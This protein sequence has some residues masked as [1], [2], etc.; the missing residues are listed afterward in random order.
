[1]LKNMDAWI[2]RALTILIGG[3]VF[4]LTLLSAFSTSAGEERNFAAAGERDIAYYNFYLSDSVLLHIAVLFIFIFAVTAVVRKFNSR[5]NRVLPKMEWVNCFIFFIVGMLWI[6]LTRM[7]PISVFF[8]Y[9]HVTLFGKNA[10]L[11]IQVSNLLAATTA[12][13]VVKRLSDLIFSAE[14][15]KKIG[16]EVQLAYMLYVPYL[17]YITFIY[18]TI[19]GFSFSL[20]AMYYEVKFL[21]QGKIKYV[22][23][24]ALFISFAVAFKTNSLIMMVAMLLFLIYDILMEYKK[25]E[26]LFFLIMILLAQFLFTQGI[27]LFMSSKSGYEV[28]K[29]MPKANWV[30]MALQESRYA[31]GTWNGY[32]VH[33]YEDANYVYEDANRLAINSIKKSLNAFMEDKSEAV[34]W[35]GKKMAA[36]W[37]EPYFGAIEISRNREGAEN[38]PK[39]V[40]SII[41]GRAGYIILSYLNFLQTIILFG[42]FMYFM[43]SKCKN[44]KRESLLLGVAMLGGFAFHIFGE[45]KN[46]YVLP[47]FLLLIPYSV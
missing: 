27:Q 8:Y 26:S 11:S 5:K 12:L 1:M 7:H 23:L 29:G 22:F 28:S 32:S 43:L 6:F 10:Y 45:G 25:K 35:P 44:I 17:L 19:L 42:C 15:D 4:Y 31:P 41:Y 16:I 47:Y 39:P 38:M 40:D 13:L 46:Q 18:G 37:N 14:S 30:A 9:L 21:Q 33:L 20:L 34:R 36:Q 2:K 3:I 24:S